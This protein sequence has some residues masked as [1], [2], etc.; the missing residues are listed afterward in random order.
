LNQLV[1]LSQ[2]IFDELKISYK[3]KHFFDKI[4][5]DLASHHVDTCKHS[6]RT[7]ILAYQIG[8]LFYNKD[9]KALFYAA[10]LHDV[11]KMK[12]PVELL[13]KSSFDE[14][15]KNK[16]K[17]HAIEGYNILKE[18][19]Y[20]FSAEVIL[21]VHEYPKEKPPSMFKDEKTL[22]I[23]KELGRIVSICDSYDA[24]RTRKN[25][26]FQNKSEPLTRVEALDEIKTSSN[27]KKFIE[28]LFLLNIF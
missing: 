12:I 6:L 22:Y 7:A 13:N 5:T 24:M 27:Y 8:K 2:N 10:L 25:N 19:K 3:E 9:I 26:F 20:D 14:N 23:I 17:P 21:Y 1:E 16:I 11:G 15:D 4:L 28:K 18:Q